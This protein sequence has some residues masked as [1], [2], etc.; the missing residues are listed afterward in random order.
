MQGVTPTCATVLFPSTNA[1]GVVTMIT[2]ITTKQPKF[3]P[4][5]LKYTGRLKVEEGKRDEPVMRVPQMW[6]RH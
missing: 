3:E 1:A 4:I 2:G 6:G 5:V